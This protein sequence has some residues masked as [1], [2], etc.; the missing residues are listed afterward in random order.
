MTHDTDVDLPDTVIIKE[1]RDSRSTFFIGSGIDKT[2]LLRRHYEA[3]VTL[4]DIR[5]NNAA[6]RPV[7]DR[8]NVKAGHDG[9]NQTGS[10]EK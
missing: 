10:L 9:Q 1:I 7:N 6:V 4:P 8:Y 5:E 2:G 3:A